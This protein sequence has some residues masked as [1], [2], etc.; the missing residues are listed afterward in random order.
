MI[1]VILRLYEPSIFTNTSI[2]ARFVYIDVLREVMGFS[3]R[4][5]IST[6]DFA[7]GKTVVKNKKKRKEQKGGRYSVVHVKLRTIFIV[8]T[9]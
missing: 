5:T 6:C 2:P 7:Y 3:G 9:N 1:K 4:P 8:G